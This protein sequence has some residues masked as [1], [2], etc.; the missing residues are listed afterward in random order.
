MLDELS[1]VVSE[2][3]R[4]LIALGFQPDATVSPIFFFFKKKVKIIAIVAQSRF[5]LMAKRCR[6]KRKVCRFSRASWSDWIIQSSV[7]TTWPGDWLLNAPSC[8]SCGA[9]FSPL[10]KC[11]AFWVNASRCLSF[12]PIDAVPPH[13]WREHETPPQGAPTCSYPVTMHVLACIQITYKQ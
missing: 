12:L 10:L 9:L 8:T 6:R 3:T 1:I 2:R 13:A 5:G 11:T 7:R 4:R